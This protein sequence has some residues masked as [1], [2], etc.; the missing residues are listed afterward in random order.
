MPD[1]ML[2]QD[3]IDALL[4]SMSEGPEPEPAAPEPAPAPKPA[5]PAPATVAPGDLPDGIRMLLDVDVTCSVDLG[6]TV[7]EFGD[8][9]SL[10][11]SS[12]VVL[13]GKLEDPFVLRV[14]G[15]PFAH[16]TIV[17]TNGR[18][19]LQITELARPQEEEQAS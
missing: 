16:G 17:E 2:S 4:R 12:L 6:A 8:L 1:P 11:R 10:K 5:P 13:D 18:Y 15:I 3:E 7:L 14:N 9:L 19:G